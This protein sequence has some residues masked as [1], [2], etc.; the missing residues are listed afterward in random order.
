MR[1]RKRAQKVTPVG[2]GVVTPVTPLVDKGRVAV[3]M[4]QE[5]PRSRKIWTPAKEQE[6]CDLWQDEAHLYDTTAR[7][8]RNT[9]KRTQAYKRMATIL[10]IDRK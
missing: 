2:K 3:Q 4:G 7:D 1:A 6:L 10:E 9:N 5:T 8:Y